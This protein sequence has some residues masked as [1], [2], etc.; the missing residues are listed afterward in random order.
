MCNKKIKKLKQ[1]WSV[2]D[3]A[4]DLKNYLQW[5]NVKASKKVGDGEVM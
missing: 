2:K 3:W 1:L 4:L 5:D